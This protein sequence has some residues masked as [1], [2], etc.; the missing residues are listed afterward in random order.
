[1]ERIQTIESFNDGSD[2]WQIAR[3]SAAP[4]LAGVVHGYSSWC[5]D[6]QSFTTRRELASTNGVFI[7]NL[8]STL[9]IVDARGEVH[10]LGAG[11]GF[12]G[13]IARATSL[14]RSTGSMEGVHIHM[15]LAAIGRLFQLPLGELADR[16]VRL[17]DLAGGVGVSLA[18]RLAEAS[19]LHERWALLDSFLSRRFAYAA[20]ADRPMDYLLAHL[21][22]GRGVR[23]AADE[24][25]WS[26]KLL[27][28][29]FRNAT[30]FLPR[31]FSALARFERFAGLLQAEPQASLAEL[32]IAAGYSDQPHL[33]RAV[34]RF[35]DTTPAELRARLIPGGGGVRD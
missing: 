21:A 34:V 15:S 4:L 28:Q 20:D 5:E 16:V 29:R 35:A 30:G 17:E 14:S 19:D 32:A 7:V 1:M 26:R 33:T 10:R 31:E 27:A 11:E 25:G 8:G 2:R 9:E 13:G 22:A 23:Q 18:L 3:V 6:T 12:V 24:L